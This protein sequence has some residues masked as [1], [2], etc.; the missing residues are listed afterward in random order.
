MTEYCSDAAKI[1][2]CLT[3]A[4]RFAD[5]AMSNPQNLNLFVFIL[6]K[7]LFFI[8]K[9]VDSLKVDNINDIIEIIKNHILTIKTESS[10]S[11][12]L[13]EIERY[14]D[15][16]IA[17]INN[18]KNLGKY[19]IFEEILGH[20]FFLSRFCSIYIILLLTLFLKY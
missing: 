15:L 1:Q 3:K 12:F 9:G 14:F 10:N 2:E 5:F 11:A 17:T 8:E 4:K 6:N 13:P 19:K 20:L 18:R 16:T 7:Y